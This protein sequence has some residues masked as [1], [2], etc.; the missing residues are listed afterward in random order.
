VYLSENGDPLVRAIA[1][2]LKEILKD[3]YLMDI[4][5][6]SLADAK[7]TLAQAANGYNEDKPT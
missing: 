2:R 1:E 5:V 3:E 6:R 7:R 4:N